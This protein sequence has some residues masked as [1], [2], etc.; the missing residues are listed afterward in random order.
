MYSL[1]HPCLIGKAG[2]KL[3]FLTF[4][5]RKCYFLGFSVDTRKFVFHL[6]LS[7]QRSFMSGGRIGPRSNM[8]GRH[9]ETPLDSGKFGWSRLANADWVPIG[10]CKTRPT[11]QERP[12]G[13]S[14]FKGHHPGVDTSGLQHNNHKSGLYLGKQDSVSNRYVK[15]GHL[16]KTTF[17]FGQFTTISGHF[18]PTTQISFTKF[19]C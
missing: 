19:R 2:K 3:N 11:K 16:K 18:L 8:R 10:I 15:T 4:L 14:N 7:N 6:H 9:Q 5:I 12:N 13:T 17:P 1:F